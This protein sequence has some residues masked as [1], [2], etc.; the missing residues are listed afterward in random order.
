MLTMS[1]PEHRLL[2]ESFH[3]F[4]DKRC[5]A[6]W[7]RSAPQWSEDSRRKIWAEVAEL[8]WTGLL[9]PDEVGGLGLSLQE[10]VLLAE[11]AGAHL[12][13][14]ALGETAVLGA[15]VQAAAP[16]LPLPVAAL[17]AG[18]AALGWLDVPTCGAARLL[19]HAAQCSH[20][21]F[22][23]R[24]A[25]GSMNL[26]VVPVGQLTLAERPALDPA[27]TLAEWQPSPAQ[28]EELIAGAIQVSAAR[29]RRIDA[30]WRLY[31][32]ADV[33]GTAHAGFRL[34]RDYVRERSQF[35]VPIGSFQ[36]VKH[37]LADTAIALD[38]ATLA[39][40]EAAGALTV[41]GPDG[42]GCLSLDFAQVAVADAAARVRTDS[43][44]LHG[45]IG[46]TW[47]Y[48][49]HLFQKRIIRLSTD[50]RAD[51]PLQRIAESALDEVTA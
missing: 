39:V 14:L 47:E 50:L 1:N 31:R 5:D 28:R 40:A 2:S 11:A 49:A 22:T 32:L 3:A 41:T 8:G 51:G 24:R 12:F 43:I 30:G 36:A 16:Q 17:V 18:D 29:T 33:L 46:Y 38:V 37:R 10:A 26:A 45:A 34:T 4:L 42:P 35:G 6:R 13:P 15:L 48:D 44:Q 7:V 20:V 21:L 25:D 27:C 23:F 19:D 9:F